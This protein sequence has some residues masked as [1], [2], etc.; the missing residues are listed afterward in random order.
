MFGSLDEIQVF[1]R[2]LSAGEVTSIYSAGSAGIYRVPQFT[3]IA[4][5][6]GQVLG[7]LAGQPARPSPFTL[8]PT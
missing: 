7:G 5:S 6:N 3:N 8:P 2:A 1:N 4:Q